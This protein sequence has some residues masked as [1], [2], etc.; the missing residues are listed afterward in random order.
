MSTQRQMSAP[1]QT[2]AVVTVA[3][4]A[5]MVG[6][7]RARFYQLVAAGTLPQPHYDVTTRRPHYVEQLQQVCLEVRRRNCGV[8]GKPVL[9]YARRVAAV[10][11]RASASASAPKRVTTKPANDPLVES[12]KALGLASV[13]AATVRAAVAE[14][15]PD[16]VTGIDQGVVIRAVFLNLKRG[17]PA[18]SAG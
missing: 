16:G 17:N 5:R 1:I 3:E 12:I 14:V 15:F 13:T 2:K 9:F 18:D 7:S 10:S 8:D 11:P 6:L 4:M